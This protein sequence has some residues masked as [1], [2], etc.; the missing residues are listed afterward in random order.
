[1]N[2]PK[3]RECKLNPENESSGEREIDEVLRKTSRNSREG[4]SG[5]LLHS[6]V[7]HFSLP[8]GFLLRGLKF[9]KH[10]G[11]NSAAVTYS[12]FTVKI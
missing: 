10:G 11:T 6:R 1:M 3:H 5:T 2:F 9:L 8:L 7:C 12:D 4:E